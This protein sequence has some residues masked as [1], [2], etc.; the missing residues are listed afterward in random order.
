MLIP[1]SIPNI[2]LSLVNFYIEFHLK[3]PLLYKY[4]NLLIRF[5]IGA[6]AVWFIYIKL[7]N[8][9][10]EKLKVFKIENFIIIGFVIIL[11]FANWGL[12]ALKWK[13]VIRKTEK[14]DFLK[15]FRL[16]LTGITMGLLTPNRI[17][18]IPARALL[19][20]SDSFKEITLK[21]SV[22]SF[23]Q[24]VI[25]FLVGGIGL[26]FTYQYYCSQISFFLLIT[27]VL[28]G[29]GIVLLLYFKLNKLA[30]LFDKFKLLR[31]E[32][33]VKALKGFSFSELLKLL[34]F[35]LIR[36][37]VFFFQYWLVL[38]AFGVELITIFDVFLIPVCFLLSS[39]I[40]TI[41]ISEIGVR[42]SV[43]L[44]IYGFISDLGVQIVLASVLLWIINV[45]IPALLGLFGL[46]DL[47]LLK[48]N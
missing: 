12:E 7:H 48:E 29:I 44:F 37:L 38:K 42:G 4:I 34:L 45:S 2:I 16:T 43:A 41:L 24:V 26:L 17:G 30:P 21:T 19:L 47:K 8:S 13:F 25:T 36:Y 9:F 1:G 35:S 6:V 40:P 46:K 39:S 27:L 32:N 18:E 5:I 15:A 33:L 31:T 14:I 11:M 22:S 28:L 20:R 23:S 10:I 3:K